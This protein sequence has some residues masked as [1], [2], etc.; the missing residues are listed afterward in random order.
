MDNKIIC[1][2]GTETFFE[3]YNKKKDEK[4]YNCPACNN[5]YIVDDEGNVRK[6]V[7]DPG[8]WIMI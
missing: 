4:Y 8:N 5:Y 1:E 3:S 6:A 7:M 2:C